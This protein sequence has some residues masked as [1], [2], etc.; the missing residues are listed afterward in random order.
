MTPNSLKIALFVG[1][2]GGVITA[3]VL[4]DV[5]TD[6]TA[7]HVAG[8][9]LTVLTDE[10]DYK[11]GEPVSIRIVNSGSVPIRFSDTSYGLQITGLAGMPIFSPDASGTARPPLEPGGVRLLVWDQTDYN[12]EQ[13]FDGIYKISV[14]GLDPD[15]NRIG[16]TATV[17]VHGI[18]LTFGS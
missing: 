18:D 3:L 12:G 1:M 13:V 11:K 16:G 4:A 15:S 17:S 8:P 9:S 7:G 2:A 5:R 10:A 14:H 6:W